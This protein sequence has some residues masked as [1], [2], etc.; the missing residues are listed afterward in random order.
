MENK[1]LKAFVLG[2][3]GAVGRELVKDLCESNK[4]SHVTVIVRRVLDQWKPYI[5]SKK[6]EVIQAENLDSLEKTEEWKKIQNFNSLFCCL[7]SRTKYGKDVFVQTDYTYPIWGAKLC[8][9]LNIPH[10]SIVSAG[11][12][13]P[14]SWFLYVKTKGQVERDLKLLELPYLS[15]HKPGLITEREN[16]SR[17]GEKLLSYVPF[18][19]KIQSSQ[20]AQALKNEAEQI[21]FNNKIDPNSKIVV[22]LSNKEMLKLAQNK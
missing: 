6:L 17:M 11:I 10:Y 5:D 9:S 4:W 21:H 16:D 12:A 2:G 8:K 7:G 20:I 19:D 15:I 13:N 22:N 14:N 1:Q 3:T 18:M